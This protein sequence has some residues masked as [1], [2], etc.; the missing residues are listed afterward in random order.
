MHSHDSSS[1]SSAVVTH[2]HVMCFCVKSD[3]L[4]TSRNETTRNRI[5]LE[6]LTGGIYLHSLTWSVNWNLS[7][8][9]VSCLNISCIL[10]FI[11]LNY[12][13]QFCN[14]VWLYFCLFISY[15]CYFSYR[16]N[17]WMVHLR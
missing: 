15:C 3:V 17:D 11:W 14:F 9:P 2:N 4:A 5:F 10:Y 1:N 7:Q 13:V 12:A 8:L 16:L 6:P